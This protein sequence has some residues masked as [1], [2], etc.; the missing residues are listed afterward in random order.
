MTKPWKR[1]WR[2]N[3]NRDIL[4]MWQELNGVVRLFEDGT[5]KAYGPPPE[6]VG[7]RRSAEMPQRPEMNSISNWEFAT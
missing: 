3:P 5:W 6:T 7:T 4:F 2:N 1:V